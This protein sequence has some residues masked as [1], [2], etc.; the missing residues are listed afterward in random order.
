MSEKTVLSIQSFVTHGYVGNKAATFPL[1]LHGFDVDGINTVC[2]S[3]HS[4]YP[5]IRGHRMS[6]QEYDELMEGVR[7]NNFLSNYRY[8]LT[9]YINNVDIIGRIRDTLKEVRELREKE[10]KKLT[11]ICDPVMGDDGIMYCKKEVL[12]A[13]RELVPL[14][15]IVTPNYFE[16]SLLSGV[17][18]N[19]LSSAILAADWFHNCGVAHVIIKS[20]REQEN[21]TH[22]RF[23]YSVKEGSEAVVRRFSGVVPYHEGRYTGTGDVFAACLLAFSHSH[24][25]DVAIGKSMAVLQELIIA[26]RKEGGD[27]KSSL[28]SRELRVVASPQ[29]VLQP[30]TVVDVKPIS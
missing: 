29:V 25:M 21:P 17:T 20:F 13:Y 5:V 10:D 1:Q 2:L 16:A 12:D 18:V 26:T 15:D 6:L 3:N 14:A 8:I 7:A 4:G 27:G 30:S 24:P 9:G 19:D 23:L 22:L 28:K 11:F